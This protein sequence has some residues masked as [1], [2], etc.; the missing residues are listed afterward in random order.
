MISLKVFR[1]FHSVALTKYWK[2]K[3]QRSVSNIFWQLSQWSHSSGS[4]KIW[5]PT[6]QTQQENSYY[7]FHIEWIHFF[8]L[9]NETFFCL[10]LYLF[11]SFVV[12]WNLLGVIQSFPFFIIF[13]HHL[14]FVL[15]SIIWHFKSQVSKGTTGCLS[16][17][18]LEDCAKKPQIEME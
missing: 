7:F 2:Q 18:K 5:N 9:T 13:F 3:G 15:S 16:P 14:L 11:R 4:N 10:S 12:I 1:F 6:S 17:K 8:H